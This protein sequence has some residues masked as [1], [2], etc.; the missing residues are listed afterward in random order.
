MTD[1]LTTRRSLTDLP[2]FSQLPD[3]AD[4]SETVAQPPW[5]TGNDPYSSLRLHELPPPADGHNS[6]HIPEDE[7]NA[8]ATNAH[9]RAPQIQVDRKLVRELQKE[10]AE[11]LR[12][13]R[14]D[15]DRERQDPKNA[16][17]VFAP[18]TE[19]EEREFG[20]ETITG[21]VKSHITGVISRGGEAF[22][23]DEEEALIKAIFDA[24]FNLGPLQSLVE[25]PDITD[26]L[27]NGADVYVKYPDGHY[28]D[29]NAVVDSPEEMLEWLTNLASRADNGGRPFSRLNPSLRLTLRGDH[30]LSGMGYT[31]RRPSVAIR[32]HRLKNVSLEFLATDRRVMPIELA[33]LLTCGMRGGISVVTSGG[34]GV[35]KT[36]MTRAL[37]N[38]LPLQTRI[39]TAETE[40]ELFLDQLP[41]REKFVVDTETIV[42]GGE[43]GADGELA[44]SY[45]LSDILYDFVRQQ[46]DYV[47]VGE[48]AGHEVLAMF[49]AMQMAKGGLSTVHAYN[50]R[51]AIDRLAELATEPPYNA[52]IEYSESQLAAHIDLIVQ[53]SSKVRITGD[54][55]RM[56]RR[57]VEEV[58]YVEP[59]EDRRPAVTTIYRGY[60]DGTGRFG[61]I[62]HPL[63]KKLLAG[64][65]PRHAFPGDE[66]HLFKEEDDF[67]DDGEVA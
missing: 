35:G 52:P 15:R 16:G 61:S 6:F 43:R 33:H 11:T 18:F 64:G 38:A 7:T 28:E 17:K 44:G 58:I 41:G 54:D 63:R 21:L 65:F 53:L 46:L 31:V 47:I 26:I 49:K 10:A 37:A 20:R 42:G 45:S 12:E 36:T 9:H 32:I 51:S 5:V 60:P 55:T 34:M 23:L 40:R 2:L 39:G 62:P 19:E 14:T 59:G 27:I 57:F 25:E 48:V 22:S 13:Y 67:G 3:V 4:A 50:A 8:A 30:R 29:R 56:E 1:E 66:L 24:Q